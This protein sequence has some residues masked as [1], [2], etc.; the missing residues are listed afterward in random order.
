MVIRITKY[1]LTCILHPKATLT[2]KEN[3]KGLGGLLTFF[4]GVAGGGALA[5]TTGVGLGDFDLGL[6]VVGWA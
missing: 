6:V 2:Y 3:T 5:D 4:L 1:N